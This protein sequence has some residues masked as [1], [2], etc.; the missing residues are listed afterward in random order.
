MLGKQLKA[1]FIFQKGKGM[2]SA[3][4]GLRALAKSEAFAGEYHILCFSGE[5]RLD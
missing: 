2:R 4:P 1:V 3:T 5:I